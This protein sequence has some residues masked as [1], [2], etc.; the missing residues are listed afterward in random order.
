MAEENIWSV[1]RL[2]GYIKG[3]FTDD[4][5]LCDISVKGE[6]S[7]VKYHSSGHIYFT[8]KDEGACISGVMFASDSFSLGFRPEAGDKVVIRGRVSVYEKAGTYQLYA[9]TIKAAGTGE[10]YRKFTELKKELEEMGMFDEMYKKPVPFLVQRLGVVTASTGA[11]VR[12]IINVSKRRNPYVEI[13]LY[14]AKVQGEGAADSIA[15]GIKILENYKPNVIIVGRGG[16]SIEDLWAFN[17]RTVAKAI[18]ECSIPVISGTGHETDFTIADFVAD[19]R[20]STPSAAAEL[21]VLDYR[22]F[23]ASIEGYYGK[24]SLLMRK[25]ISSLKEEAANRR[26]LLERSSPKARLAIQKERAKRTEEQIKTS[27]NRILSESRSRTAL[28][29]GA[30]SALSPLNTLSRGYSFTENG[31]GRPVKSIDDV[32]T[33]DRLRVYTKDGR[34]F[35]QV[36]GKESIKFGE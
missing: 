9:K 7:N 13:I 18:F 3:L 6:L 12:D 10:L 30:L 1:T 22:A 33:E 21:A 29:A 15:Y 16:G 11:A 14:P 23:M 4:M 35:A 36:Y 19:V 24:L 17:E 20:A 32:E 28:Y 5:L 25:R 26:M 31:E 27:F 34:I 2:N 8:L